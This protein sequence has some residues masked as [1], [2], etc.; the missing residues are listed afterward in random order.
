M[1]QE[2]TGFE[3][4][5]VPALPADFQ[6]LGDDCQIVNIALRPG[7]ELQAEPGAMCYAA[8]RVKARTGLGNIGQAFSRMVAG[9]SAFKVKWKNEGDHDGFIGLTPPAPANIIPLNMANHPQGILCKHGAFLC[10]I[11]TDTSVSIDIQRARSCLACCC[12]GLSMVMEKV[13]GGN[14]AFLSAH[15]TILQKYL[16]A[17]ETIVVDTTAV[18]ALDPTVEVDVRCVGGLNCFCMGEGAFNT[19]LTG[20]GLVILSSLPI[21][22]LRRLFIRPAT[23]GGKGGNNENQAAK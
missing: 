21:D 1:A 7:Q 4:Y 17:G 15:G 11:S 22:K 10:A 9:E 2:K 16:E 6:I 13:Y 3:V 20:P 23:Q 12:S 5:H 19:T 14:W 8:D 18:I